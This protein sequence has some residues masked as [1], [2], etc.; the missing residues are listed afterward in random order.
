MDPEVNVRPVSSLQDLGDVDGLQQAHD[1]LHDDPGLVRASELQPRGQEGSQVRLHHEAVVGTICLNKRG[2]C[3]VHICCIS[4]FSLGVT[5][6]T[7][8]RDFISSLVV[9]KTHEAL[10]DL[11]S[12]LHIT[13]GSEMQAYSSWDLPNLS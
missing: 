11:G 7:T 4:A 8:I 10:L 12:G 5:E 9:A 3:L 6:K 2:K 13:N 1:L